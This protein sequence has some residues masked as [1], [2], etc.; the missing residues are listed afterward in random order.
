MGDTDAYAWKTPRPCAADGC[1]RTATL[2]YAT[3]ARCR[4]GGLVARHPEELGAVDPAALAAFSEKTALSVERPF[5]DVL[6]ARDAAR[7]ALALALGAPTVVRPE[8]ADVVC[9]FAGPGEAPDA[10]A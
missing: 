2:G 3:C 7:A 4:L 10:R 9:T 1:D 5:R 8:G 6:N